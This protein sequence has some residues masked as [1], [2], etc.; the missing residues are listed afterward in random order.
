MF[1]L[2]T[3]LR[4]GYW[5]SFI[6]IR[7]HDVLPRV[8]VKILFQALLIVAVTNEANGAGKDKQAVQR[9]NG[10]EFVYFAWSEHTAVDHSI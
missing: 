6:P 10:N 1:L 7:V 5:H 4:E 9:T 3:S 8:T 2:P